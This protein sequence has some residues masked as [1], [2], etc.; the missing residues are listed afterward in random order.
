MMNDDPV[1][2]HPP[3]GNCPVCGLLHPDLTCA[4]TRKL[5]LD[6]IIRR[7]VDAMREQCAK[8]VEDFDF[9]YEGRKVDGYSKGTYA[10]VDERATK[11]ALA[12]KI[13]SAQ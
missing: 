9:I 5:I 7:N 10:M 2:T 8:A 3:V 12:A 6:E 1:A 11:L 4:E 13:R